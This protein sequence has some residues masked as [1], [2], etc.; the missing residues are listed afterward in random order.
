MS[1]NKHRDDAFA[2][3]Q[4]ADEALMNRLERAAERATRATVGRPW[5]AVIAGSGEFLARRLANRLLDTG[6]TIVSLTEAW[7]PVA[8]SAACAKA[9][10]EL[11]REW[12]ER[13]ETS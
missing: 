10:V 11:V 5:H 4:G 2:F 8:S 1:K 6:G 7:G 9:V 13:G 3:A 12:T